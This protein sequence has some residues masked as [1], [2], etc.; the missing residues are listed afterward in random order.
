M[1]SLNPI[2]EVLRSLTEEEMSKV[3]PVSVEEIEKALEQ[4]MQEA[5]A[6]WNSR[7]CQMPPR[8]WYR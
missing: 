1:K 5:E 4:G 3:T 7:S 6:I 8:I 2:D